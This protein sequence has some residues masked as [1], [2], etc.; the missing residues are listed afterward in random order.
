M[1]SGNIKN[2]WFVVIGAI[3]IQLCLGAIY[4]WSVFTPKLVEAD[5]TK[6]QTQAVFAAGL[7]L[8]AIVMVIAGRLLPKW[9]PRKLAFS[10]GIVLGLGYL[11]A[12]LI[13]G[14]SFWSIFFFIGIIGV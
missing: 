2:R 4:A 13:G 7:A 1:S 10:G 6:A 5:W 8:F 11:L 9:G 12:G 3:L 14:T